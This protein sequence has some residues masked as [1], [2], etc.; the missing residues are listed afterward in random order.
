VVRLVII[1]AGGHGAELLS[2]LEGMLGVGAPAGHAPSGFQFSGFID[3]GRPAGP[4]GSASVLGDVASLDRLLDGPDAPTHY[5]TAIG[6]N[7]VRERLVQRV[8]EVAMGRIQAWT[9]R[10]PAASVGNSA[11]VGPGC[12]LAPGVVLTTRLSIGQH[13]ILNVKASVS[14]DC[15]V[16]D[17][18]NINPGATVCGNVRIGR[19]CFIGAGATVIEQISIGDWTVVGAGAVVVSDLPAGV[20][21][22]G[23]PARILQR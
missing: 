11:L 18:A 6:N 12:L 23:V 21:A 2:Y 9:L 5:L 1:G 7:R 22:V 15:T 20:T 10:H 14:H 19:G 16:G 3:D 13:S 4:L 8:E 17:F